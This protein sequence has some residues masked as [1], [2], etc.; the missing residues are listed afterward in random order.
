MCEW[1]FVTL[2]GDVVATYDGPF[3]KLAEAADETARA[4]GIPLAVQERKAENQ[5][6]GAQT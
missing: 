5:H 3:D 4:L 6:P 1:E 2:S